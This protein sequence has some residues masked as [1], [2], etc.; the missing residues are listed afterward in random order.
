MTTSW[1]TLMAEIGECRKCRLCEGRNRVVPGEGNPEADLMFIGSA[2]M[3]EYDISTRLAILKR[4]KE[5]DGRLS[6]SDLSGLIEDD[7][8]ND[9]DRFAEWLEKEYGYTRKG[10]SIATLNQ[11]MQHEQTAQLTLLLAVAG[12]MLTEDLMT[13]PSGT[14][15]GSGKLDSLEK[16]GMYYEPG[17][18]TNVQTGQFDDLPANAKDAYKGYE[19]NGWKG[20][21]SGQTPGTKAGGAWDNAYGDLPTNTSSGAP[22]TYKE[23]DVNNKILGAGRDAERFL[24]GSDGSIYYTP[25]HYTTLIKIQ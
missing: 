13:G 5:T 8:F 3:S 15:F 17:T 19:Q 10:E 25:N 18:G 1:P 21:Y 2:M 11:A 22:I 16:D 23:F 14:L 24:Y 6:A 4:L 20:N 7:G 12:G 9:L